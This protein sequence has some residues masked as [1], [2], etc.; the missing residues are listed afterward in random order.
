MENYVTILIFIVIGI[1][2]SLFLMSVPFLIAKYN[3]YRD[4][5]S[6]YECGVIPINNAKRPFDVQ[7]YLVGI[8]FIIFDLEIVLLFPFAIG[9][10]SYGIIAF[11][12]VM[13]FCT[14]LALGLAYEWRRGALDW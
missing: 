9:L 1:G 3:P 4:K 14:I 6:P 11:S 7:F 10:K 12:S 13:L 5:L 8:L 2:F